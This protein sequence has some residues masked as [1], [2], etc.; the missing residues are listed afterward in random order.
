MAYT[1]KLVVNY[2][3]CAHCI[4][5]RQLRSSFLVA[6]CSCVDALTLLDKNFLQYVSVLHSGL[7]V[8]LH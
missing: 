6:T 4:H 8:V 1:S 5:R 7:S 2:I 3:V